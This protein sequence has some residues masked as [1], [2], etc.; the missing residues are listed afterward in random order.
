MVRPG[1]KQTEVGEIPEDWDVAPLGE[2][3]R[4]ERGKFSARPRNDPKF[5]G[6][7]IPFIQTGD[8]TKSNGRDV[9]YSQT[10]NEAGVNVSKIFPK[11]SLYFTIAANIGDLAIVPF[12]AACPDSLITIQPLQDVDKEW[13]FHALRSKKTHFQI[14]AT[15]N[16]QLNINLEKL[17]PYL[18]GIP[19]QMCEQKAIAKA[20][21]DVDE[22]IVSLEKLIAKKRD[23]KTAAMQ[24]LLTGKKRLPGF[25]KGKGYKQ[26]EL[27]EIPEDWYVSDLK[28]VSSMYGRIGWQGLKQEEFTFNDSQPF[29][30]TGVNFKDGKIRWNEVYHIPE[31]RFNLDRNIQLHYGDVLMTKD[32]TIGKILFVEKIPYPHKA[33]LNSHLLVF[34]PRGKKY[35][36]KYLYY[37]LKSKY[38]LDFIELNKSGSTFFGITQEAV[39]KFKTIL[40]PYDEQ[41]SIGIMLSDI[42][43]DIENS[44]IELDKTKQIKQGMMQELLTG[45]TRLVAPQATEYVEEERLHGT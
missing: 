3:A 45:R 37:L 34:R 33:S 41:K 32:G 43:E 31:E 27:G 35:F 28:D 39:G 29:L 1:Y 24:Q 22:L 40:P 44:I 13:L 5:F 21:S 20:L 19:H 11:N 6:G 38:F 2:L 36:P 4:L 25:G 15:S 16:A 14:I 26:T 7:D 9:G 12:E 8:V 17:N 30:I 10:L 23:I 18:L 42:D